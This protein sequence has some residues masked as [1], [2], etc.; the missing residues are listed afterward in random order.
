MIL[1]GKE[2]RKELKKET[3]AI[4]KKSKKDYKIATIRLGNDPGDISYE[5]GIVKYAESVGVKLDP[6]VLK[7]DTSQDKLLNIIGKLNKDEK[8]TGILVFRPLLKHFDEEKISES[9]DPSKDIDGMHPENLGNLFL[10]KKSFKPCTALSVMKFIEYFNIDLEGKDMLII[11][12]TMVLGKPLWSMALNK[13]ATITMAHSKTKNLKEKCKNSDIIVTAMGKAKMLD[14]SYFNE[15]SIILDVG[16]SLDEDGNY[17]GDVDFE[18]VS[19]N[20]KYI[21][22]VFGGIGSITTAILIKQMLMLN[23]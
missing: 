16:M 9:I 13:N 5:K 4:I 2:I 22:P 8:I 23:K 17:S 1:E 15:D 11:N 21:T 19:E 7:K 10:N 14:M 18:E 3:I 12:R 20:V 6:I